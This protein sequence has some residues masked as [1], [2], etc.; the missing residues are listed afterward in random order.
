MS[1]APK[2]SVRPRF[3][4][5]IQGV[6]VS[7]KRPLEA[8]TWIQPVPDFAPV[9]CDRSGRFYRIQRCCLAWDR[10]YGFHFQTCRGLPKSE[11]QS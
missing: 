5:N 3:N 7:W 6:S 11:E 2:P 8:M 4:A 9:V 1:P 10:D